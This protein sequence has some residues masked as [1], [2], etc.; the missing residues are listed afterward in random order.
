MACVRSEQAGC[1]I[2]VAMLQGQTVMLY[3]II[4]QPALIH[5]C[6]STAA[7]DRRSAGELVASRLANAAASALTEG[8]C[9]SS[10]RMS[11][12]QLIGVGVGV[13]VGAG[14]PAL[15]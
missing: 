15:L 7:A 3:V 13:G 6:S 4:N 2:K 1:V 12:P 5:G 11:K 8:T 10:L 14:L 9:C